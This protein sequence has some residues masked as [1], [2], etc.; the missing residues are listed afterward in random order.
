MEALEGDDEGRGEVEE[1][2]GADGRT[3]N[4]TAWSTSEKK[5]VKKK[6]SEKTIK[7]INMYKLDDDIP[8][9]LGLAH[10]FAARVLLQRLF[11]AANDPLMSRR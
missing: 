3:R 6:K 7:K 9:S 10:E 1:G 8:P 11:Q 2:G 5:K 4:V